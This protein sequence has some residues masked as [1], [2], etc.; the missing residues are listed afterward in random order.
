MSLAEL[1]VR[2]RILLSRAASRWLTLAQE[3]RDILKLN[4]QLQT[5]LRSGAF[6]RTIADHY[7]GDVEPQ[8]WQH[9]KDRFG[10]DDDEPTFRNRYVL[11][12]IKALD[13]TSFVNFGSLYGWLESEVQR[14]GH[15]AYGVDR[16]EETRELNAREFPGPKFIAA[17]IFEFLKQNR[18]DDGL[19]C[20][21]NTGT[22]F[23]PAFLT[24]LYEM[25]A[26]RGF[27]YIAVWEPSPVSRVTGRYY[28][29]TEDEQPPAVARGP[30]LLNN[31][32]ALLKRAGYK[33]IHKEILRPPHRHADFRS[34]FVL[35]ERT[36]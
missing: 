33:T 10:R 29:Y 24:K 4:A 21:I 19:F 32:P 13:F 15:D 28:H 23:L 34:V 1:S 16:A 12:Q 11:D 27:R 36:N 6:H 2:F 22:Y 14:L 26:Q 30:M 8:H 25:T 20:H 7:A 18:F 9:Y 3:R 35:A 5:D 31:Y 17:D